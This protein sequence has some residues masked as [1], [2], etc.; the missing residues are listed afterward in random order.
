M[1]DRRDMRIG[2]AERDQ[3]IGVLR[4]H[5]AAGRVTLDE[6]AELVGQVY[7]ARTYG[8]LEDLGHDLPGGLVHDPSAASPTVA[9]GATVRTPAPDM[10]RR[11]RFLAIMSAGGVRGRWRAAPRLWALGLFGSV[12]ID[13]REAE[14]ESP[15][16]ELRAWAIMGAVTVAVPPGVT[17]ELDGLVLMG[18]TSNRTRRGELLP[19]APVVRIHARGLWGGVSVRTKRT[20]VQR[21]V[22]AAEDLDDPAADGTIR[23]ADLLELPRRVLD[24]IAASLPR[25]DPPI[26]VVRPGGHRPDP[27][28]P[29]APPPPPPPGPVRPPGPPHPGRWRT[30]GPTRPPSGTLTMMVTDLTGSTELAERLGDRRWAEVL[31]SH[32]ALV[33]AQVASHG[34]TEIKAQGD[35]FLVVFPSARR[36]ILAAIDVQRAL[37]AHRDAHLDAPLAVRIGLHTGEVV[38]RDGDVLGQHVIVAARLADHAG[39]G[40]IVTSALTRD[41]TVSGGDLSFGPGEEVSLKGLSQTWRVHRVVW[42]PER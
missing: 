41:L 39:P 5:A 32:D 20:R 4:S 25:L 3:A 36:A 19:G 38:E 29:H 30:A 31:R 6:F 14:I 9:P 17:A 12:H 33:R 2:D 16:V 24:D 42:S 35:G 13:L 1:P 26:E 10:P 40:E 28:P 22:A 8:E 23:T 15:V 21:A 37:R 34:G 27:P 11:R 18:G 7:A